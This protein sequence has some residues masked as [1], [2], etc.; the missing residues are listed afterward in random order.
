MKFNNKTHLKYLEAAPFSFSTW[1]RTLIASPFEGFHR[2]SFDAL[3]NAGYLKEGR[4]EAFQTRVILTRL[5]K[6]KL[7]EITKSLLTPE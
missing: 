5:G 7:A 1:G 4:G 3:V 2:N 6:E